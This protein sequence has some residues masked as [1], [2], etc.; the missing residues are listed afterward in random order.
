[1]MRRRWWTYKVSGDR[2][3]EMRLGKNTWL[4]RRRKRMWATTSKV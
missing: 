4:G 1:M 2:T 3:T